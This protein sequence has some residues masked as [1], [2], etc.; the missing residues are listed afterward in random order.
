MSK[1]VVEN[2]HC[3]ETVKDGLVVHQHLGEFSTNWHKHNHGQ[4]VYAERGLLFLST[5]KNRFLIP[6]KFCVW[7]PQGE[8]HQS[9][10]YSSS[11]LIRTIHLDV[12]AHPDPFYQKVG[13]YQT[14]PLL[15]EL[16]H[17]SKRW[18]ETTT[19]E[20]TERTFYLNFKNLLPDICK[21][22]VP[23]T[24]PAPS[25][26]KLISIV[27]FLTE[28]FQ[29]KHSIAVIAEQFG[30][31]ERTLSRLFQKELG[32]GMLQ[33]LKVLKLIKALEWFDEGISNVSEVV[34][35]LGYESVST[36][37]N[38]FNEVLGYRPQVYLEKRKHMHA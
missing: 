37:S 29:T 13:I 18:N 24:L 31:S 7:I 9:V 6:T 26:D 3:A 5:Q 22:E 17:Y 38:T 32:M 25:S 14:T 30:I 10:S 36:F 1:K 15:E 23:L 12:S 20:D 35:R 21:E 16:I 34:Y 8:R 4:L 11:L 2:I 28:H 27:N 33:F 19:T